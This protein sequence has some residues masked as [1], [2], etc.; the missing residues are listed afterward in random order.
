[1]LA[2]VANGG[3]CLLMASQAGHAAVVRELVRAGPP[4][5][6]LR[7]RESDGS[8][9]LHM[10]CLDG[11]AEV[12]RVLVGAGAAGQQLAATPRRD[13]TTPLQLARTEGHADAAAAVLA[14]LALGGGAGTDP[15]SEGRQAEPARRRERGAARRRVGR[16]GA[17]GEG[18]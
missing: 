13:G 3:T 16:P 17:A 1:M 4:A 12:V 14:A 9:C 5:L 6:L 11:H 10:A 7:P 2:T 15:A 18:P 8:T